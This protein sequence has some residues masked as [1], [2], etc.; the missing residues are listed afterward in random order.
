MSDG[1]VDRT[2]RI[3]AMAK[4]LF[5]QIKVVLRHLETYLVN[6]PFGFGRNDKCGT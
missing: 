2:F 4:C 3:I 6:L 5:M 1:S